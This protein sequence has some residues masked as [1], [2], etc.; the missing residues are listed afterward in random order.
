LLNLNTTDIG[1]HMHD[2]QFLWDLEL[3]LD[4][5]AD[6]DQKKIGDSLVPMPE[7]TVDLDKF[8]EILS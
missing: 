3:V 6:V 7:N 5:S 8:E 1:I 2:E 4:L